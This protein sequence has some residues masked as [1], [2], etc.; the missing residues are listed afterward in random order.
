MGYDRRF[1]DWNFEK[2]Y[3]SIEIAKE[4]VKD[5][6]KLVEEYNKII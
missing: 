5:I 2:V 6:D 3:E 4:A 1:D